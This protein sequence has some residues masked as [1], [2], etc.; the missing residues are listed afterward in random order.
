MN[1]YALLKYMIYSRICLARGHVQHMDRFY[2][3][4]CNAGGHTILENMW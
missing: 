4:A 2:R 1:G 3:K